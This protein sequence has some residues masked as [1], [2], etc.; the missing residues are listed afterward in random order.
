LSAFDG[1][2]LLRFAER[3]FEAALLKLPPRLTRLEELGTRS[4]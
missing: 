1:E 2:S 4:L 3:A